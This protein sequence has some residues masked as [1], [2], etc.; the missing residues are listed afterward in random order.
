MNIVTFHS[1]DLRM[2]PYQVAAFRKFLPVEKFTVILGPFGKNPT[3][4]GGSVRP[5]EGEASRL[6]IEVLNAPESFAGLPFNQRLRGLLTWAE[7]QTTGERLIGHGDLFPLGPMTLAMLTEGRPAAGRVHST[8]E[9]TLTWFALAEGATLPELDVAID[10]QAFRGWG[11]ERRGDLGFEYCKPGFLHADKLTTATWGNGFA[12]RFNLKL[13]AIADELMVAG[14]VDV[15]PLEVE[16]L[17]GLPNHRPRMDKTP[18]PIARQKPSTFA[19]RPR[20]ASTKSGCGCSRKGRNP[21]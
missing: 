4:S 19:M 13:S 5:A 1:H 10:P 11:A 21:E 3:T 14:V 2:L 7:A 17:T 6:G 20:E 12:E 9:P 18:V 8:G 16:E 15:L